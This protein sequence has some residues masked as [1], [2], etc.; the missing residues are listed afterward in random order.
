MS[1]I[2]NAL[3][4]SEQQR[5]AVQPE[6]IESKI[7]EQ[8]VAE[9]RKIPTWVIGLVVVNICFIG[10]FVWSSLIE[11]DDSKSQV[12]ATSELK[13]DPVEIKQPLQVEVP[14]VNALN[15]NPETDISEHIE[16]QQKSIAQLVNKQQQQKRT[17]AVLKKKKPKVSLP[18]IKTKPK[19]KVKLADV[20]DKKQGTETIDLPKIADVVPREK[21]E[22][23]I[24]I[25]DVI[26]KRPKTE[27]TPYLSE[28]SYDFRRTVPDVDINVFVYSE[29]ETKRFIMINM[30]KYH[31]GEQIK[32]GMDL[33]GI[34]R[35]SLV[36]EY[37]GRV[38]R[39][40]RK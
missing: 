9:G 37:N 8:Q 7:L 33:K 38:F 36:V 34:R 19:P 1:Y 16:K 10:F 29:D 20:A 26:V 2:L 35:D 23:K 28:L 24:R 21:I 12:E 39:I 15:K 5:Q 17:Q 18:V 3:K 13:P 40:K 27:K 25:K 30:Q 31:E 22:T 4:K 14:I 6:T 11:G 32:E